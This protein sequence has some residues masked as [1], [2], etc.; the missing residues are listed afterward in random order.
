MQYVHLLGLS[1]MFYCMHCDCIVHIQVYVCVLNIGLLVTTEAIFSR[2]FTLHSFDSCKKKTTL[3]QLNRKNLSGSF[4]HLQCALCTLHNDKLTVRTI[5]T[6]RE[7][8][9]NSKMQCIEKWDRKLANF[10]NAIYCNF[11]IDQFSNELFR[12]KW[13]FESALKFPAS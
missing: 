11:P 5:L 12:W 4:T 13:V 10:R 7:N 9:I 3:F 6:M 1:S 8:W 2:C